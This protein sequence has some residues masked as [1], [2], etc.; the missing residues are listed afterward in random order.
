[1]SKLI[2]TIGLPA[3]GKSTWAK[4][5]VAKSGGNIKRINKD[6]MRDM[7]DA[8][9]WGKNNEKHILQ[10]RDEIIKHYLFDGFSVI[11]DDT[12][13]APK[14]EETL[15]AL[16]KKYGATFET[17]SFLDV[18]L[19]VCIERDLKRPISVGERVIN[20]MY[21]SFVKPAPVASPALKKGLPFAVL[22]DIDGTLA[23]MVDRGPFDW[24]RVGED[25]IDPAI[26]IVVT[27][28]MGE[29]HVIF[30]SGRDSVCRPETEQWLADN[31]FRNNMLFMRP[32]GDMRKD[33]IVKRE[34]YEEHI[35]D[36]FNVLF[37]LDDRNQV[38]DMWRN[39]LGLKV[40]QVAE[41][42]F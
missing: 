35:K 39:E 27:L 20:S 16:A 22:C 4:E 2:M 10:V 7:I 18:P 36:K 12:N 28:L 29:S 42:D 41:G 40:L 25:T 26:A 15:K 14:H 13:L 1:M 3:S 37:V 23:H 6:D 32:E 24:A 11:V 9:K 34:L 19:K 33:N 21:N 5:Q 17:K 31:G 30:M 8:G 38:V